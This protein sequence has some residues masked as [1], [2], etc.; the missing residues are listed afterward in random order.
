MRRSTRGDRPRHRTKSGRPVLHQRRGHR[1]GTT[2]APNHNPGRDQLLKLREDRDGDIT[3][4]AP[5]EEFV[6]FINDIE[7]PVGTYLYGRRMYEA[8]IF[9]ET[10]PIPDQPSWVVDF[11]KIW[12]GADKIVFSK[13]LASVSS[14]RTTLEREFNV[15]AIRQT[16]ADTTHDLTVGGADLAAQA[17]G[18]GLVEEFHLF[19]WPLA[20]GG[21]KPAVLG[22]GVSIFNNSVSDAPAAESST[23][24]TPSPP[25]E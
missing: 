4:G 12:R 19:F 22:T 15:K 8:M 1:V 25:S 11:T 21:G 14:T 13:T 2:G 16:K 9:W 6:S 7:R 3:F 17:I 18:A 5:D 24:T 10:A 23:F 20:L